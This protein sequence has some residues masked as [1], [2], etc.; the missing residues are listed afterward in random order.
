MPFNPRV[1]GHLPINHT[2]DKTVIPDGYSYDTLKRGFEATTV[3]KK[4][5]AL[6]DMANSPS[7]SNLIYDHLDPEYV[8]TLK[9]ERRIRNFALNDYLPNSLKRDRSVMEGMSNDATSVGTRSY[10]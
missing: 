1:P 6:V 7:R 9:K 5:K 3:L 8:K 2:T 4:P 10:P